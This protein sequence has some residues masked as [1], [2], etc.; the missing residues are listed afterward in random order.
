MAKMES[1]GMAIIHIIRAPATPEQ[2]AEMRQVFE[3]FIKFAGDND[4]T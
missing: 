2:I 4:N 1:L 3:A